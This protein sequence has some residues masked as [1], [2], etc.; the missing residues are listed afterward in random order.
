MKV[1]A[2]FLNWIENRALN[3]LANSPRVGTIQ[4]RMRG[5]LITY[6]V[7]DHHNPHC[8]PKTEDELM[9]DA[10]NLERIFHQPS[11]GEDE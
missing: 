1:T 6:I 8:E 2:P 3:I 4:V 9:P 11:Y 10:F 7:R 5:S